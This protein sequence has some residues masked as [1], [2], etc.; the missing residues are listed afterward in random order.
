VLD[1]RRRKG[2]GKRVG[3]HVVG[4]AVNKSNR[5]AFDDV[6]NKME[7]DV[8]VLGT[9]MVLVVFG[10]CNGGLIVRKE[11]R[12]VEFPREKLGK[13]GANPQGLLFRMSNSNIFTLRGGERNDFL[14]FSTPRNC[15]PM[16]HEGIP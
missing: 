16:K 4:R 7:A 13:E 6:S 5:T 15:S 1:L 12:R 11:S 2:F 9:S 3:D 14:P 10:E 8:D